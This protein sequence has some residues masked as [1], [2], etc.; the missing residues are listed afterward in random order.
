M[1]KMD[2]LIW[3]ISFAYI[4]IIAFVLLVFHVDDKTISKGNIYDF[5]SGWTML[6]DDGNVYEIES[7]PFSVPSSANELVIIENT[8]PREYAGLTLSFL[9]A[10]KTLRVILDGEVIYEFGINDKRTFGHTPGSIYNFIDIPDNFEYGNIRIEMESPYADYASN[11][12]SM[13]IAARDISILNLIKLNAS[14]ILCNVIILISGFVFIFLAIMNASSKKGSYGLE[15]MSIFCIEA[16]IYYFIET[17]SLSL[18][19]GNQTLYSILIFLILMV[20]PVYMMLYYKRNW[21]ACYARKLNIIL[22]LCYINI[23]VQLLLQIFNVVDFMN[24]AIVSHIMLF[25]SIVTGLAISFDRI[26]RIKSFDTVL[27]FISLFCMGFGATLDLIRA[28]TVKIGDFGK[29]SR[30]GVTLYCLFM[31]VVNVQKISKSYAESIEENARLLEREVKNMEEQNEH[32]LIAKNEAE[33]AKKEALAANEAKSNFLANMSHEI[34]TPINALLGMDSMIL[35]ESNQAQ[36]REYAL[37]IQ[38]AGQSLLSLVNDILDFS[39]IESGNMEI[40][41]VNYDLNSVINDCYNMIAIQA[42]DKSL[43]IILEND[44]STPCQLFGDEVRIRQ[45]ILNILSNA[46]KYTHEGSITL[47]LGYERLD[48]EHLI[49]KIS[50][51][52]T[53]IGIAKEDI[54]KIFES[55]KRI[56]EVRNRNIQGTGL[57]LSITNQ[58]VSQMNGKIHVESE[59]G[60]GSTFTVELPQNIVEDK[61]I[62]D[63]SDRFTRHDGNAKASKDKFTA[64]NAHI[65]IVDDVPMNLKVMVG[66]LKNTKIKIDTAESGKECLKLVTETKY[67]I[68]FL[69]HMMPE[70]DGIEVLKIMKDM[71]ENLNVDTPVIMLTANAISGAKEEYLS[72]G[73]TDYMS[74]PVRDEKLEEL[75]MKYLPENLIIKDGEE[76]NNFSDIDTS[77]PLLKKLSFLNIQ[78]GLAY[79][80][81]SEDIYKEVLESYTDTNRDKDIQNYFEKRDWDNY[82]VQVHALKSTSL[83]IG[84]EELSDLAK[85]IEMATR[86]ND[87]KFIEEHHDDMVAM[88]VELL[89]KLKYILS[90]SP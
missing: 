89:A 76:L 60:K 69:D 84:A 41:P 23:F 65:L 8:I 9:S 75:L 51:A 16:C 63:L 78:K 42:Y 82:R 87:I 57:G 70:M 77:L 10:D 35:K 19:Y 24:M 45:I 56:D 15:Y 71:K 61:P 11:V 5:N 38:N 64:P 67:D 66:L 80:G 79:C 26:R 62:G 13:S 53:G 32:L 2:K 90:C 52:D 83:T 4:C 44:P 43:K 33:Q 29:Y 72:A 49:L 36:I 3:V 6:M 40:V 12:G 39:K 1:K 27:E 37:N 30:Y 18:F 50:V 47:S 46:V 20:F 59:Y 22:I 25:I 85:S 55:F 58:L 88:Y 68:I 54:D 7:L 86:E 74:K 14:N 34:R 31:V 17:K 48:N 73:F 81:D 21:E 28:H